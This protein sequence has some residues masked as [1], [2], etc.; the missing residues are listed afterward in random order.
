LGPASVNGGVPDAELE[1]AVLEGL[2]PELRSVVGHDP[3]QL[4]ATREQVL[5]DPASQG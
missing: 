3:L 1:Q 4:D 5:G 2:G